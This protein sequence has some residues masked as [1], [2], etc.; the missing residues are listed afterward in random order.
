MLQ[1]LWSK[2]VRL[3]ARVAGLKQQRGHHF[4]P[5]MLGSDALVIDL[6]AHKG[7]FSRLIT[8]D[9]GCSVLGLE[10]NPQLYEA[11]PTLP[12]ARFM[13]L[14]IHRDDSP[15]VFYLSEDPES[16][17][18]FEEVAQ[19]TGGLTRIT[20]A[21]TTLDSLLKKNKITSVSLLKVDIEGAEFQMLERASEETLA[22]IA[23]ITVEFHASKLSKGHSAERVRTIGQRLR[24]LGFQTLAM[25][26]DYTD[27]L[28][29]NTSRIPWRLMERMAMVVHRFIIMPARV[30]L[31]SPKSRSS[32]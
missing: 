22:K 9:Y 15:V 20:V 12:R 21:G 28:F 17:S 24:R 31:H 19:A 18:L 10:A 1:N 16:S 13:N 23:Q 25:D 5:G 30:V 6:G 8:S 29:L 4:Y 14:A 7:E 11:L 32:R 3:V 27:V 2:F 26:R